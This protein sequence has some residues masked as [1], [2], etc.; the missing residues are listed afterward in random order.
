MLQKVSQISFESVEKYARMGVYLQNQKWKFILEFSTEKLLRFGSFR[1]PRGMLQVTHSFE[2]F[3]F[4]L[5]MTLLKVDV[6]WQ[7]SV[8]FMAK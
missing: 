7:A 1:R 4:L 6:V 3:S 8:A 5:S 2:Y